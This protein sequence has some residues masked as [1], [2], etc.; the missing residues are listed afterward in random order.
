MK[1]SNIVNNPWMVV[2]VLVSGIWWIIQNKPSLP[3]EIEPVMVIELSPINDANKRDA[4]NWALRNI[5]YAWD[6]ICFSNPSLDRR[7]TLMESIVDEYFNY[8]WATGHDHYYVGM[9]PTE[10]CNE[11]KGD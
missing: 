11:R 3:D 8:K 9:S 1:I 7:A 4:K 6:K 10:I 2:A 5:P